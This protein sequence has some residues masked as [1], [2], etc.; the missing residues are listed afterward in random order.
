MG[1]G[2]STRRM[3]R[4]G[5]ENKFSVNSSCRYLYCIWMD[6]GISIR[7]PV[8]ISGEICCILILKGIVQKLGIMIIIIK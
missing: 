4:G 5:G 2:G 7:I 1:R 8:E 3:G 6:H